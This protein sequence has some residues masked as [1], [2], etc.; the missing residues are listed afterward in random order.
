VVMLDHVINSADG[1][2]VEE[3]AHVP[4]S[5]VGAATGTAR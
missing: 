2:A 5:G 4:T 3:V 1:T